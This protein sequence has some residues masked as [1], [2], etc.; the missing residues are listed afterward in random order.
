[1]FVKRKVLCFHC[2]CSTTARAPRD[3]AR[4]MAS[5]TSASIN[6]Y[7]LSPEAQE[8]LLAI[9]DSKEYIEYICEY[10]GTGCVSVRSIA[11]LIDMSPEMWSA[12]AALIAKRPVMGMPQPDHYRYFVAHF[13]RKFI[14]ACHDACH[15]AFSP[16]HTPV[17]IATPELKRRSSSSSASPP[18][19]KSSPIK[20]PR[21]LDAAKLLHLNVAHPKFWQYLIAFTSLL[22]PAHA[23]DLCCPGCGNV[24]SVTTPYNFYSHVATMHS[25]VSTEGPTTTPMP[26]PE[27]PPPGDPCHADLSRLPECAFTHIPLL[28]LAAMPV[29]S[30][31]P[32]IQ[33]RV[34]VYTNA[35][36]APINSGAATPSLLV[37]HGDTGDDGFE[38]AL[39]NTFVPIVAQGMNG[40][41]RDA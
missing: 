38:V 21:I 16:S 3:C 20:K 31:P 22:D 26:A 39:E 41:I 9:T 27:F 35:P 40:T 28:W 12:F 19:R 18:T 33:T 6:F 17:R 4:P 24:K 30:L 2:T 1:V 15:N 14:Q 13:L 10:L 5:S 37:P 23:P 8:I 29:T 36:I 34:R 11:G 25:G 32:A 7:H